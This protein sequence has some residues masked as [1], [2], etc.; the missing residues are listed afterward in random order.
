MPR[1]RLAARI[2]SSENGDL[3]S[4]STAPTSS[5]STDTAPPSN[6]YT[7][8]STLNGQARHIKVENNIIFL[9]DIMH[10]FI[11]LPPEINNAKYESV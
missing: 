2:N 1:I 9:H 4:T 3:T 11:D 7:M 8:H 10:G 5:T 6:E